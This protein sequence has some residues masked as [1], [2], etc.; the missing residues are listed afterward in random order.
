MGN[1][2]KLDNLGG[3]L[4]EV[5]AELGHGS[6]FDPPLPPATDEMV[7]AT[8][9]MV[10]PLTDESYQT[11]PGAEY[12]GIRMTEITELSGN[13]VGATFM[14]RNPEI[15]CTQSPWHM[16]H[17]DIHVAYVIRGWARFEFEGVGEIRVEAGGIV[18]QPPLNRHRELEVSLDFEAV[19]FTLPGSSKTT[20]FF[21][22]EDTEE[23]EGLEIEV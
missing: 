9:D 5:T 12:M 11:I 16:H 19:E 6:A 8:H 23:Y 21:F 3:A 2:L 7:L 17:M 18:Y 4:Q 20:L 14:K 10:M 22:D 15:P 13:R 1:T